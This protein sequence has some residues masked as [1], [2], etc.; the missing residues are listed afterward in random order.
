VFA[1]IFLCI[2][3]TMACCWPA[4]FKRI[5]RSMTCGYCCQATISPTQQVDPN[6][7]P[8][9]SGSSMFHPSLVDALKMN[10]AVRATRNY[11]DDNNERQSLLPVSSSIRKSHYDI[12]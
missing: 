2:M 1:L 9:P 4:T 11:D 5:I 6:P 3:G 10:A 7:T 12:L 8:G